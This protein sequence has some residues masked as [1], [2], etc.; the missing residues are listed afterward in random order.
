MKTG[1]RILAVVVMIL[2]VLLG[3]VSIAGIVGTWS[4]SNSLTEGLVTILSRADNAL[5]TTENALNRLNNGVGA[6][7]EEVASF[8]Q[9]V[10]T[11]AEGFSQK[12]AALTVLS[13]RLDLGIAPAVENV[14]DTVQLVRETLIGVQNA[15]EAINALPFVSLGENLPGTEKLS[16]LSDGITA[17]AEGV[18]EM[19]DG[20]RETK[21]EAAARVVFRVGKA[22]A[23]V[24]GGLETIETA[25]SGMGGEVSAVR[26]D[27]SRLRSQ[28]PLWLDLGA[29]GIT[30][31]LL[32]IIF[33]HVVTFVLGLS[34]YQD[35][36]L[37]ARWLDGS[38]V[39]VPADQID[40]QE[41]MAEEE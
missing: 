26:S 41:V 29:A 5:G 38:S 35:R 15:I 32:W 19:R 7:R 8:E 1:K 20:I 14:R 12:P 13:E 33:A 28:V 3:L 18:Q 4:L 17:L 24:D 30:L 23:R 25:V 34:L 16:A 36:N 22:T 21:E 37:F 31:I 27:V 11:A 2:S 40:A 6:A 10:V 9:V 39:G